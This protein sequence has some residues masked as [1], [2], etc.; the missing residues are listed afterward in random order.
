MENGAGKLRA[1]GGAAKHLHYAR[2][3]TIDEVILCI[4]IRI[5]LFFHLK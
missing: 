5:F 2:S 4:Y 1:Y 3:S